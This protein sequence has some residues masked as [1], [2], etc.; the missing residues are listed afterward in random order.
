MDWR[1]CHH[2][3]N[4]AGNH[5][6]CCVWYQ[7][8]R[9]DS[10]IQYCRRRRVR[11]EGSGGKVI[12]LGGLPGYPNS[13]AYGI[14]NV[15]LVAGAS[16]TGAGGIALATK[17][18]GGSVITLGGVHDSSSSGAN[19]VNG[20][21][22]AVGGSFV[23]GVDYATK[24]SGGRVLNLGVLPGWASSVAFGIN[25]SG[26]VVGYSYNGP[27]IDN[28][29]TSR[30]T[31]WSN[32]RIIN[33]LGLPGSTS[34]AAYG[35]N[36]AGQVVGYSLV[37]EASQSAL[38]NAANAL[39]GEAAT[40]AATAS[41]GLANQFLSLMLDPFVYGPATVAG[42][43][44]DAALPHDWNVWATG[45][46]GSTAASGDAGVG[47][48]NA[49]TNAAGVAGGLGYFFSP[50]TTLGIALAGSKLGWGVADGLG[51]GSGNAFQAGLYGST[52]RGP[53]YLAA[54]AAFA[55]EWLST[56]RAG[57]LGGSLTAAFAARDFGGRAELGDTVGLNLGT[58]P[59]TLS[60]YVAMQAQA[61]QGP[62]YIE[63][64][65]S[66]SGFGQSY[67]NFSQEYASGEV[68]GRFEARIPLPGSAAV[69]FRA[70]AAYAHDAIGASTISA[71]FETLSSAAFTVRGA[72]LPKNAA[73]LTAEAEFQVEPNLSALIKVDS[74]LAMGA[75]AIGG[76]ATL[77]F[78][79]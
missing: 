68:G 22:K 50:G 35:I 32:G 11:H 5:E 36:D 75:N 37:S 39:N 10:G 29:A 7:Q 23:N 54:S 57:P 42:S 14:N 20:A 62:A 13:A 46:G 79:F 74:A 65:P 16:I 58:Q 19:A 43:A 24:W 4:A 2:A 25:Q 17:W 1:Q 26:R 53:I 70:R 44:P 27:S 33:L 64:D 18:N 72:A 9:A 45:F 73:L 31:E 66:F 55:E 30:A 15:G 67:A 71:A 69:D 28:P 41:I 6:Q 59:I 47:S 78:A 3:G 76:S 56:S 61:F 60:P 77:R 21:G 49:L 40:G 52:R 63:V 48:H 12:N 51:G 38:S 34:S 8:R